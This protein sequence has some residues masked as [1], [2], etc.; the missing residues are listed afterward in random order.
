MQL[1]FF[2]LKIAEESPHPQKFSLAVEHK[3]AVLVLQVSPGDIQRNAGL[4][5][6]A[7]EIGEQGTILGLRPRFD[8]AVAQG[9]QLVGN[10]QVEI[11]ING[12]AES[13]AARARAIRI[14]EGKQ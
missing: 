13:L 6:K 8:R 3:I 9:L 4:L 7:L 14:V 1:V 12:V 11:E 5:G 2:A 10:H